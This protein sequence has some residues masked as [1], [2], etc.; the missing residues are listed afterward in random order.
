MRAARRT[1]ASQGRG[2]QRRCSCPALSAQLPRGIFEI[3]PALTGAAAFRTGKPNANTNGICTFRVR[4]RQAQQRL[5][6]EPATAPRHR[7]GLGPS[8]RF[9]IAGV[10][11][12][13]TKLPV[14]P[15]AWQEEALVGLNEAS[16]APLRRAARAWRLS[17]A[18]SSR[19]R[20][21]PGAGGVPGAPDGRA[22]RCAQ[23]PCY[24]SRGSAM[25]NVTSG[26]KPSRA[27]AVPCSTLAGLSSR[28]SNITQILAFNH[29]CLFQA[30][31]RHS[32][33]CLCAEGAVLRRVFCRWLARA[34]GKV[35]G[36][37]P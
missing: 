33:R 15:P 3:A 11:S 4:I 29:G 9:G 32:E 2:L 30:S 5:D 7:R 35:Q 8:R 20:R 36:T 13:P 27:L 23:R 12:A 24:G 34:G 10:V 16:W 28:A 14:S 37:A 21:G 6:A 22:N 1:P 26:G 17:G 19:A 31:K 25:P 18:C